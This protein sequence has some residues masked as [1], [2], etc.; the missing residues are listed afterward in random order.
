MKD[1]NSIQKINEKIDS[2]KSY[3]EYIKISSLEFQDR[4]TNAM[5]F[6]LLIN[7]KVLGQER[8][9]DFENWLQTA[10]KYFYE[11]SPSND[12]SEYEIIRLEYFKYLMS[13]VSGESDISFAKKY[14]CL[15]EEYITKN[16]KLNK[17]NSD[18][19]EEIV[20]ILLELK[21]FDR[22]YELTKK[23]QSIK[24]RSVLSIVNDYSFEEKNHER[25]FLIKKYSALLKRK[26]N[27]P[28]HEKYLYFSYYFREM[29]SVNSTKEIFE[30][31]VFGLG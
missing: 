16:Y 10:K 21:E 22:A 7:L 18:I 8:Q 14:S 30:G 6:N 12:L 4:V 5:L 15:F 25:E 3:L 24:E 29:L 13:V 17:S 28:N 9:R 11:L 2:E 27:E 20:M 1:K 31:M 23:I 26:G 19:Y